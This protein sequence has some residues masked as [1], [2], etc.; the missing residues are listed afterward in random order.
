MK[1]FVRA[2]RDNAQRKAGRM[3]SVL[4][5]DYSQAQFVLPDRTLFS[6][7][8]VVF[9]VFF[10]LL[11]NV[12]AD[13]GLLRDPDTFWHIAVG[14]RILQTGSFPWVD[15][16]S[17]TFQGHSWMA[18]DW[19]SEIIFALLYEAGG[20][21]AV[22]GF[23]V[24]AV[25]LTFTLLFAEMARQMRLT[26]ALSIAM[27]AYALSSIHFLARPH[28][29]SFPLLVLWFAGLVR[30]V[31]SRTSPTL[32][33]LPL[34][35]LW[36]NLHGSFTLGLSMGSLLALEAIF[37]SGREYRLKVASHWAMF[38]VAAAV[39][40]LVTPYG[41]HSALSTA[42][43]FGGN[44]ALGYINEWRAWDF[45]KEIFG[46]PL[47][48]G[49][50]FCGFLVGVK[51]RFMRLVIVTI[52]FY[53]MLVYIRMVPIFALV[54]PI[55]ITSSLRTQFPFLSIE[56]QRHDQ[57]ISSL[58]RASRPRYMLILSFLLVG[59]SLLMLFARPIGPRESIQPV[60]AV[61]YILRTD[62]YGRVYNDF[63]F[64]GYLIFRGVKSFIDGRTDQLFGGGFLPRTFESAN[65]PNKEFLEL[66]DEYKV[67]SALVR[68]ES[69][70]A[71]KLDR[72]PAWQRQYADDV[73]AVYQRA[74]P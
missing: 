29:L 47:I 62:P 37:Q 63:S 70:E 1:L 14:R 49:L 4:V 55:M 41:Y 73:A 68:P 65:K 23:S 61:D 58:L 12:A 20:W 27:L 56:S 16:L 35:T 7:S 2:L 64:G 39:A 42:Q 18:K 66:L 43:V 11:L 48:I 25:A 3:N 69:G 46:G 72:T 74:R 19:L 36:A 34:M 52:A 57:F 67:S 45:S 28:L 13:Y 31:E 51:I 22:V 60:A 17:H 21:R 5:E 44:E 32:L 54:T 9:A 71:M 24:G 10:A 30:A 40:A 33:L 38:L 15:N 59:P 26:A 50:I 8:L 53:M 6:L